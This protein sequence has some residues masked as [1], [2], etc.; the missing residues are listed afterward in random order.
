MIDFYKNASEIAYLHNNFNLSRNFSTL[1]EGLKLA[2]TIYT[3]AKNSAK[4]K[5]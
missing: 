1:A 3:T 2:L 5:K 4:V